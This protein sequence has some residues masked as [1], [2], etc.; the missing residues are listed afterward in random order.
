MNSEQEDP[1]QRRPQ[2]AVG[3]EIRAA[4]PS[5]AEGIALIANLPGFRAGTLRLPFQN[6]EETRRW[7]EKPSPTSISL[8]AVVAGQV[9][10][11]AG[12]RR[13]SGR[14]IHIGNLG[15]GVHDNFV[16]RGIGSA[17]LAALIDTADNWLAIKRLELTVYVDNEPAIRLYEKFGF[18]TEGRLKAFAFRNGEYVDAFTMA[19]IRM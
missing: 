6:I 8:V 4:S 13:H 17:L 9:V 16:G 18:E 10:G 2:K 15:M 12:L 11:N 7:L 3:V 5:D 19:R 14:Q 1:D